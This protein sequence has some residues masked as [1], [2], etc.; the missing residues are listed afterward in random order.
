MNSEYANLINRRSFLNRGTTGIGALALA[1]MCGGGHK[2]CFDGCG[3]HVGFGGALRHPS[4]P[5]GR[6]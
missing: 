1:A 4:L 3:R 2:R 6:G 5:G